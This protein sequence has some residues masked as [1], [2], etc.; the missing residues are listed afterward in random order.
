MEF[1]CKLPD[2]RAFTC[3]FVRTQTWK[4]NSNQSSVTEAAA[5]KARERLSIKWLAGCLIVFSCIV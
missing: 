1:L 5:L 4:T 3:Y 2:G